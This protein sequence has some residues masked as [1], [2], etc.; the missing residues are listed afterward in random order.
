MIEVICSDID[1]KTLLG[2]VAQKL[3]E[4]FDAD[5]C[6]VGTKDNQIR[7]DWQ[8]EQGVEYSLNRKQHRVCH[9]GTV[10]SFTTGTNQKGVEVKLLLNAQENLELL[11]VIVR[12]IKW[13]IADKKL[14]EKA[15]ESLIAI[16]FRIAHLQHRMETAF[17]YQHLFEAIGN[18]MR[19]TSDVNSILNVALEDTAQAL[20]LDRGFIVMLKYKNPFWSSLSPQFSSQEIPDANLEI[21]FQWQAN[22]G[23]HGSDQYN[24]FPNFNL[25]DSPLC[26][27]AWGNVPQSLAISDRSE[28]NTIT[29]QEPAIFQLQSLGAILITPLIGSY[30]RQE[31]KPLVLGFCVL[32][33]FQPHFWQLDEIQ[34]AKWAAIQAGSLIIQNQTIQRVQSLVEERTAQLKTSL[35][36]QAKLSEQ[37]RRY[38]EELQRLN[39]VKDEFIATLSDELKHPLT[40]IKMGIEMLKIAP[41][42]QQSDRYLKILETECTKE[43]NLVNDL[44]TLQ[45][46]ESKQFKISPKPVNVKQLIQDLTLYYQEQWESK[47]LTFVLKFSIDRPIVLHT[48]IESLQRILRELLNNAGKFSLENSNI[49]INIMPTADGKEII[50]DVANTGEYI[51]PEQQ[52]SIFDPFHRGQDIKAGSNQGT[53]LGLALVKSLVQ[54]LRGTI[55]V[56]SHCDTNSNH[57]INRF[58]LTFPLGKNAQV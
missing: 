17:Y 45:Q 48:D 4:L 3:G 26:C 22:Q 8:R 30:S 58:T 10:C 14:L 38:I 24:S 21:A 18:K 29:S 53:G 31:N 55:T 11:V 43:I 13:S 51:S 37:M 2:I 42:K 52:A 40:K 23:L 50:I 54:Y 36:V 5:L 1:S 9:Q 49:F 46:L 32:I 27:R 47:G 25:R 44:L 57:Y 15:T 19:Q 20:G 41:N 28:L 16:A 56:S 34:L 12:K 7:G 39:S 33:S 35:E 6:I